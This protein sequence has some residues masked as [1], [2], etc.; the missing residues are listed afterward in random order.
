MD[1]KE[2]LLKRLTPLQYEVTQNEATERPFPAST[3]IFMKRASMWMSWA[4]NHCSVLQTNMMQAAAVLCKTD[5][6]SEG[7]GR[8]CWWRKRNGSPQFSS[9]FPSGACLRTVL[10]ELGGLRYCINSAAMRFVPYDQLMQRLLWI[11]TIIRIV[12][13]DKSHGYRSWDFLLLHA[14]QTIVP[15]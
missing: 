7:A 5:F 10:R 2:E 12:S 1:N 4:E 15:T 6:H 11:Q 13:K 9:R 3:M 8:P 14:D